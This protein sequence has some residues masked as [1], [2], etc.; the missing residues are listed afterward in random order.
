MTQNGALISDRI[1]DD[2][3]AGEFPPGTW[4][5]QI[6][7]QERYGVS[8]ST[9]RRSLETLAMRR[10]VQYEL[11]RGYRVHPLDDEDTFNAL[12]LRAVLES[13]FAPQIVRNATDEE[14]A[15][16]DQLARKFSEAS[17]DVRRDLYAVNL[18]FHEALLRCARNPQL[19]PLVEELRI[20]TSPAPVSQW[21][22]PAQIKSSSD[23]HFAIVAA[24]RARQAEA[25][26]VLVVAHIMKGD[27]RAGLPSAG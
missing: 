20:R 4:L 18:E 13:G 25:L 16:L 11:N 12:E 5:R 14:I 2:L 19:I 24:L 10:I 17:T 26:R 7:L 9:I 27:Y 1:A 15:A 8:R 23:E 22:D 3:R 21:I 6:D